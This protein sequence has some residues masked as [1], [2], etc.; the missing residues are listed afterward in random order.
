MTLDHLIFITPSLSVAFFL[1][2]EK[3]MLSREIQWPKVLPLVAIQ[4]LNMAVA[5]G[6]SAGLLLPFVLLV[7][8]LQVFSFSNWQVPVW[9]S[10]TLSLLFLD[11]VQYGWHYLSHRVPLLWRLHRLHH[12][13]TQVDTLTTWLHHPMEVASGFFIVILAAVM[14][15][16]PTV[17]LLSY[18]AIF[19]VHAAFTH[20]NHELPD[21]VDRVLKWFFVTPNFHRLHHSLDLKPGNSNFSAVFVFPDYIFNT[22]FRP[23]NLPKKRIFGIDKKQSPR[24]NSLGSY[25]Y[26]PLK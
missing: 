25:L 4:G 18:S 6:L 21:K 2:V 12:S 13:D 24:A 10:F 8:P 5:L 3:L 19:G 23:R 17:A 7:A 1:L 26:N 9:L 20:M 16:V 11:V 15:D 22:F 14:F